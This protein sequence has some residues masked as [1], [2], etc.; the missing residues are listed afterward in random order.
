MFGAGATGFFAVPYHILTYPLLFVVLP[1]ALVGGAQTRLCHRRRFCARPFRLPE[2]G[3][4][5]RGDRHR[6]H[7]S[8]YR[9]AVDGHAGR[10]RG[11]RPQFHAQSSRDRRLPR[12]A[13]LVAFLVLAV[14]TYHSGL[15]GTAIISMAKGILVYVAVLAAVIIIPIEL[16][17]Y[18]K[19]FATVPKARCFWGMAPRTIW[20]RNFLCLAGA[21][22][23]PGAVALSALDHRRVLVLQPQR[24]QAQRL[25]AAQLYLRAGADRA[26]GLHGGGGG[27]EGDAGICGGLQDLRQQF[28]HSRPVPAYPSRTGSRAWPS[29]PSASAR[30][31]PLR[32]CPSPAAISSPATSIK[33]FIAPDCTPAHRIHRWPR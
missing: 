13:A 15:H 5:G 27:R 2:P 4:G 16:G 33:E 7:H 31:C 19:I 10:V 6:R 9:A 26:F 11:H 12:S 21:G 29:P 30:W 17:G 23:G 8:L 3:A 1:A 32:S 25:P 28:R 22:F 14:Y 24:D 20:G 18:G